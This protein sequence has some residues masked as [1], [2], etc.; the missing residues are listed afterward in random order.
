MADLDEI[1]A[2]V[3]AAFSEHEGSVVH[4]DLTEMK[5]APPENQNGTVLDRFTSRKFLIAIASAVAA[6]LGASGVI[7]QAQEVT[8]VQSAVPMLYILVQGIADYKGR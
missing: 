3:A 2:H 1:E 5:Y 4:E 6:I 8:L 7:D